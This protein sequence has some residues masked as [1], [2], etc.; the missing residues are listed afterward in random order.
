MCRQKRDEK[1]RNKNVQHNEQFGCK[2]RSEENIVVTCPLL[3][4]F[5]LC[6]ISNKSIPINLLS[7]VAVA[8]AIC[9]C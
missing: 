2:L 7:H 1:V 6:E 5:N 8:N 9:R 4:L 3:L